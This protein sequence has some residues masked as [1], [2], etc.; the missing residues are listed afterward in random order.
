MAETPLCNEAAIP[1]VYKRCTQIQSEIKRIIRNNLRQPL[2]LKA[3]YVEYA[4]KLDFNVDAYVAAWFPSPEELEAQRKA[5][6]PVAQ[7]MAL[8][9]RLKA[10]A[11]AAALVK[12]MA[13]AAQ[14]EVMAWPTS[15]Q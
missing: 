6:A 11:W 12:R 4:N 2:A 1:A 13:L 5:S 8:A 14:L 10:A 15:L 3:L 9:A 7:H